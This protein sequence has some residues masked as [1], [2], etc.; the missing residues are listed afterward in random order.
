MVVR[1]RLLEKRHQS[2]HIMRT[3]PT[4][5]PLLR[6]PELSS[7][8]FFSFLLFS[9][10]MQT[11]AVNKRLHAHWDT[12]TGYVRQ[13]SIVHMLNRLVNAYSGDRNT[14]YSSAIASGG[15]YYATLL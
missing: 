13:F 3:C 11:R 2:Q 4:L 14:P 10:S 8:E 5:R 9:F 7:A 1:C 12:H 15:L 6:N